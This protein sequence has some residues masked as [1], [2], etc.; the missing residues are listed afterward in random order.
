[1]TT[2]NATKAV[3]E[4][5]TQMR[6]TVPW[7]KLNPNLRLPDP[8]REA[9]RWSSRINSWR[10]RM[11][12]AGQPRVGVPGHRLQ[13]HQPPRLYAR[14]AIGAGMEGAGE[15][16]GAIQRYERGHHPCPSWLAWTAASARA[17]MQALREMWDVF[18]NGGAPWRRRHRTPPGGSGPCPLEFGYRI[19]LAADALVGNL[20]ERMASYS[21]AYREADRA[22]IASNTPE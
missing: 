11:N 8:V 20:G 19:R 22:G 21:L 1:M 5:I 10:Y 3:D 14:T 13:R 15:R 12:P 4:L 2:E 9:Q 18:L 17:G 7:E 6:T 16:L